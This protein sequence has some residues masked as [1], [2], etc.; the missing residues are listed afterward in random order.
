MYHIVC[1]NDTKKV[2]VDVINSF[3]RFIPNLTE[4]QRMEEGKINLVFGIHELCQRSIP[5]LLPNTII[6]N[7][8]QLYDN[9][10]WLIQNYIALLSKFEV[11]DYS[12]LNHTWL[13][14][15][16]GNES[17]IFKLGYYPIYE[18]KSIDTIEGNPLSSQRIDVLFY[19]GYHERRWRIYKELVGRGVRNVVF[20]NNDLW[21]SEKESLIKRSKIILNIHFHDAKILEY[22]RLYPLL[23]S[24]KFVISEESLDR[25]QYSD[26]RL[27]YCPLEKMTENIIYYLTHEDERIK[28]ENEVK[29]DMKKILTRLPVK[30]CIYVIDVTWNTGNSYY[31]FEE[32]AKGLRSLIPGSVISMRPIKGHKHIILGAN[33]RINHEI[34][35]HSI[36]YDFEQHHDD[37]KFS[38]ENYFNLLRNFEC[39]TYSSKNVEYLK[40]KR[41]N[42]LHVPYGWHSEINRSLDLIKDIDVLFIGEFNSRRLKIYYDLRNL[43]INVVFKTNVWHS[44]KIDLISRAKIILNIGYYD[45][46]HLV[47][48]LR[49]IPLIN[50]KI[51]ISENCNDIDDYPWM[52]Q[53]DSI[54]F[55]DFDE[56][57]GYVKAMMM[58]EYI[59]QKVD[60]PNFKLPL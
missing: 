33:V 6:V 31:V 3:F 34:P 5:N 59:I 38:S 22:V 57:V 58:K 20:R 11:W 37:S 18:D 48:V 35:E 14:N 29:E 26:I 7:L 17:K 49:L 51:I 16:T 36:I 28:S 10:W 40:E 4:S 23:S 8:E 46:I 32:V 19:G 27:K 52:K 53:S 60:V 55:C 9:S 2:Y 42:A 25:V 54:I 47:P 30:Y 15:R 24:G 13:K 39:W 12:L 43:P 56:I 1:F 44:E 50:K 45:N 21:G 41:I